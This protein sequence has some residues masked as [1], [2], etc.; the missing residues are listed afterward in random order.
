MFALTD[1]IVAMWFF[2]VTLFI[3]VPLLMLVIHAAVGLLTSAGIGERSP[4]TPQGKLNEQAPALGVR[5]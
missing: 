1:F 4:A 3:I 2:P 5:A